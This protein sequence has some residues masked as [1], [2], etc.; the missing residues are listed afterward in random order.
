MTA[1][2]AI[3][4][5]Q[6][7]TEVE[8]QT[9]KAVLGAV[10]SSPLLAEALMERVAVEDFVR[11]V[12]QLIYQLIVELAAD[13]NEPSF[14]ALSQAAQRTSNILVLRYLPNLLTSTQ[15]ISSPQ[16]FSIQLAELL[17]YA[18]IRKMSAL[19]LQLADLSAGASL[20]E[21]EEMRE[22][23]R[24]LL[25]ATTAPE[26]DDPD[27]VTWDELYR[28]HMDA[29]ENPTPVVTVPL[30]YQDLEILLN[31]GLRAGNLVVIGGR[32]AMGKSLV[33]TEIARNAAIRG[34]NTLLVGLEM[35]HVEISSR[36]MSATSKVPLS[37]TVT[38]TERRDVLEP[39]DWDKIVRGY[40]VASEA[41]P[42]LTVVSPHTKFTLVHLERRL[43]GMQRKGNPFGLV[44][45]DYL[46]LLESTGISRSE[47]RQVEVQKMSRDLKL[48]AQRHAIPMVILAQLNRG[49]EQRADHKPMMADLRESGGL[50]NDANVVILLHREEVYNEDTLRVGEIDLIVAKNRNGATGTVS[51]SFRGHLA[52][53][54]DYEVN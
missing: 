47:N 29:A 32:P 15:V 51:A 13:G 33:G 3:F 10:L 44:V 20:D 8:I 37:K 53:V 45:L 25:D 52:L 28:R 1:T 30:P 41:G 39:A 12:H 31:G 34:V 5:G 27:A 42:R 26:A 43:I 48:I 50:E 7:P 23:A 16:T 49:P 40:E 46:Q 4:A 36:L 22:R 38:M 2:D 21:I 9:E 17:N 19:G 6:V 35:N 14:L 18:Y 54:E 24:A 11:P